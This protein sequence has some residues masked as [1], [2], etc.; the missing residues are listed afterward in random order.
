MLDD[1]G[2]SQANS[3]KAFLKSVLKKMLLYY[4]LL[5]WRIHRR[6]NREVRDWLRKGRSLPPPHRVKQDVLREYAQRYNLR[7][8]V[9]TG[10]FYGDMVQ[11]MKRVFAYIY[12]I[13]LNHE[14]YEMAKERFKSDSHV[15]LIYGDSG[16]ELGPLMDKVDKPALF[17]LDGHWS[18]GDTARAEKDT[19]ILKELEHILHAPDLGHVVIIDDARCFGLDPAYP[20]LQKL[21][22]YVLSKRPHVQIAVENDSIRITPSDKSSNTYEPSAYQ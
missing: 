10:T 11:A 19:P 2:Q 1:I 13:E 20:T 3:M 21:T 14:L 16:K 4:P 15:E 7:I 6:Q 8:L 5:N 18:G 12:S 22:E 17:W 9:E